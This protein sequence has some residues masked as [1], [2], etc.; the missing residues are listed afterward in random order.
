MAKS[1]F[2]PRRDD[3]LVVWH[4]C[5]TQNLAPIAAAFGI[6]PDEL[7]A[8]VADDAAL[9]AKVADCIAKWA[10]FQAAVSDKESFRAALEKRRRAQARRVKTHPNYTPPVGASLGII[11]HDRTVDLRTRRPQLKA[12]DRGMGKVEF[13]FK[14]LN[15]HGIYLYSKRGEE[16][17]WKL[18]SVHQRT[19][20]VDDRPLLAAG[21]PELRIYRA[22][23]FLH[24]EPIGEYSNEIEITC[25][26]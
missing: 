13:R 11:G 7:A 10:A 16:T 20:F 21:K 23:Y 9:K 25:A 5:F 17:A 22:V 12:H 14:K 1:D 2:M 19:K 4:G 15:S 3:D 26:P 18:I 8:V 6:T 24:D